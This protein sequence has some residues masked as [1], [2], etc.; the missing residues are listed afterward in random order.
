[1]TAGTGLCGDRA[2]SRRPRATATLR[3]P[4]PPWQRPRERHGTGKHGRPLVRPPTPDATLAIN[5]GSFIGVAST[6]LPRGTLQA[7][8][9]AAIR[10]RWRAAIWAGP[11]V[12]WCWRLPANS[13]GRGQ[14]CVRSHVLQAFVRATV[15]QEVRDADRLEGV[16]A[17]DAVTPARK[18]CLRIGGS[19]ST[20]RHALRLVASVLVQHP[21]D[22]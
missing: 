8:G 11:Q 16:V 3:V 17:V 22:R 10:G 4:L 5:A 20:S 1:M 19:R 7:A 13:P 15:L 14:A 2:M 18:A 6:L 12:M 9:L 21:S